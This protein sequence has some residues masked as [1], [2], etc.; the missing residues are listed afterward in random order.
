MATMAE[1]VI[2]AGAKNRPLMLE[3]GMYDSWKS[4]ILLYIEGKDN[5]TIQDGRVKFRLF[6]D[7][8]FQ[9]MMLNTMKMLKLQETWRS[10]NLLGD[11]EGKSTKTQEAEVIFREEKQDFLADGLEEFNSDCD[12]LQLNKTSIF[13]VEHV[14]AF[15]SDYDKE[16]TA[17]AIFMARLSPVGSVNGA[18]VSPTYDSD[19]LSKVPHYDTYHETD[20][21]NSV[22]QETRYFEH[23]VSN[24][25]S[26][27]ELTSN[28]NVISYAEYMVTIEND[29][30]QNSKTFN[31]ESLEKQDKYIDEILVLEKD[32]KK[33]QNIVSKIGQT[34]QTMHM[35]TKP[36]AFDD[37]TRKTTLG[38][39]KP[40]TS[41]LVTSCVK[42]TPTVSIV[43]STPSKVFPK[44]LLTTSRVKDSLQKVKN[45][46]DKFDVCIKDPTVISGIH[47]G[48]WRVS[49]IKD[50]YEEDVIPFVKN[51]IESFTLFEKGLYKEV[52]EMKAIFQQMENE[53]T[54]VL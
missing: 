14:D 28:N 15:D 48:S 3:K 24:I 37:D 7:W 19:I 42:P 5:A 27:D 47:I 51:L 9:V 39:Q 46:L 35:L 32:K 52:N 21:L 23:L 2:D 40:L 11:C 49:H 18:D 50:A 45:H 25:D 30:A 36:Q 8:T 20:M 43:K 1:N 31:K 13:K 33:L 17:S 6:K 12:D 44:K 4:H 10:A 29:A 26:C 54:N 16:P 41:L 38:Y 22:V 53:V 34:V